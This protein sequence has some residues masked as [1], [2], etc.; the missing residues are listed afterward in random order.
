M[1]S[2]IRGRVA[3]RGEPGGGRRGG[4]PDGG[5]RPDPGQTQGLVNVLV[6][7]DCCNKV[8]ESGWRKTVDIYSFS[9]R[10]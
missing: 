3:C 5:Q 9:S 2:G 4:G 6:S 1:A 7:R 10:G 8:P